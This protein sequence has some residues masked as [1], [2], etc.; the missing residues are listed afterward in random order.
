MQ[1]HKWPH[2]AIAAF[3]WLTHCRSAGSSSGLCQACLRV[4]AGL[5]IS[6]CSLACLGLCSTGL[7]RFSR[8]AQV[9]S[10]GRKCQHFLRP[11]LVSFANI[12]YTQKVRWLSPKP[13]W[14]ALRVIWQRARIQGEVK[15]WGQGCNW[16]TTP[17]TFMSW[18]TEELA[19]F[20]KPPHGL[21]Q[22]Q[23]CKCF[24]QP[25]SH[26]GLREAIPLLTCYH[27]RPTPPRTSLGSFA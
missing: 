22:P 12:P 20:I 19:A 14:E 25:L 17:T 27:S 24:S 7:S 16:S 15:N 23:I 13:E 18:R 26:W 6:W 4:W 8:L 1:C 3:M 9:C 5:D 11:C 2:S 10:S 21:Q